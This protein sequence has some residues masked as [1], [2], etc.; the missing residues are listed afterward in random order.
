MTNDPMVRCK[1]ALERK[2]GGLIRAPTLVAMLLLLLL[3]AY[4]L[5]VGLRARLALRSS[6][7]T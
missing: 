4:R 1:G 5:R 7:W 2:F 3:M 6:L